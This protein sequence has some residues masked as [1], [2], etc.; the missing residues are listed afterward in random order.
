MMKLTDKSVSVVYQDKQI[1]FNPCGYLDETIYFSKD[2][3]PVN[4]LYSLTFQNPE[5]VKQEYR[6]L[7]NDNDGNIVYD[8]SDNKYKIEKDGKLSELTLGKNTDIAFDYEANNGL[9]FSCISG[10]LEG[11]NGEINE[12]DDFYVS[13]EDFYADKNQYYKIG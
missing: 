6:S 10:N 4:N 8:Y 5:P 11:K 2:N 1:D 7:Y 9:V 13:K 3:D 12:Q